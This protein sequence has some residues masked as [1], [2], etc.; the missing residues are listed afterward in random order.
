[1]YCSAS[2]YL[3]IQPLAHIILFVFL[4]L[5]IYPCCVLHAV[6][7][8]RPIVLEKGLL[9]HKK[10]VITTCSHVVHSITACR[11][12]NFREKHSRSHTQG[13]SVQVMPRRYD[14]ATPP[15]GIISEYQCWHTFG[16]IET[17]TIHREP[18]RTPP[19]HNKKLCS[20]STHP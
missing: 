2:C 10:G 1:M 13:V 11:K 16:D 3:Y 6:Y 9:F 4:Y 12:I 20:L 19:P 8:N 15:H 18:L 14:Q 5:I 7:V 17:F